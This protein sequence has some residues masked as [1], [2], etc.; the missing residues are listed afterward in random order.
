MNTN[1]L[2]QSNYKIFE[3]NLEKFILIK[4]WH[5]N[6]IFLQGKLSARYHTYKY[7]YTYISCV[8]IHNN[9]YFI[10]LYI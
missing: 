9:T 5:Y 8:Y 7:E 6:I 4:D 1:T 10:L 2:L 3:R